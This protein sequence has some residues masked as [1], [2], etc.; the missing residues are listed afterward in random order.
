M[1]ISAI[2]IIDEQQV[3]Y[4]TL[5]Q[6]LQNLIHSLSLILN[7]FQNFIKIQ[8]YLLSHSVYKL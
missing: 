3:W 6:T 5:T 8:P 2:V 7:Q 4:I 1:H